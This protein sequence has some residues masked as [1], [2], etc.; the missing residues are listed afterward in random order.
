MVMARQNILTG[1]LSMSMDV[2]SRESETESGD[3][4]QRKLLI[5]PLLIINSK[6]GRNFFRAS[7]AP[8]FGY[9]AVDSQSSF[10][11]TVN[12]EGNHRIT[13][14]WQAGFSEK[15][16]RSDDPLLLADTLSPLTEDYG[17]KRYW[18]N[19]LDLYTDYAYGR[20]RNFRI[21][22]SYDILRNDD[23]GP[24]GYEDYDRYDL[25][26]DINHGFSSF[27]EVSLI[28]HYIR[29]FYYPPEGAE[30][31]N[32]VT[33]YRATLTLTSRSRGDR[34]HYILYNFIGSEYDDPERSNITIHEVTV[35]GRHPFSSRAVIGYGGGISCATSSDA[36]SRCGGNGNLSYRYKNKN[37]SF[38][39]SAEKGYD[40]LNFTGNDERGLSA[41]WLF[42]A[43]MQHEIMSDLNGD[44]SLSLRDEGRSETVN[45]DW[46]NNATYT[47]TVGLS[48]RFWSWYQA[49]VSYR[50]SEKQSDIDDDYV[51][52][53]FFAGIT[54]R[55]DL[56]KW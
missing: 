26:F 53:R 29:G 49:R 55:K 30:T 36:D 15:A 47:A 21:Q 8:S 31:N 5:T 37:S 52:N 38:L 46:Y 44:L 14:H 20:R 11:Y 54:M 25:G 13:R 48:Y 10:D 40:L 1:G 28:S 23:T 2:D 17:R 3:N 18:H 35:G 22:Y 4:D 39:L 24:S 32:D 50:Y 56:L 41:Y 33:E 45:F 16:V 9:D 7:L 6:S 12:L 42:R 27:W 43:G 34:S 51:D 19:N